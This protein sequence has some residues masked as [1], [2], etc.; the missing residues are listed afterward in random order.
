MTDDLTLT[1]HVTKLAML[2]EELKQRQDAL[3][4]KTDAFNESVKAERQTIEGLKR[5]L[6]ACDSGVR[7]LAVLE[8]ERTS[9]K[10][11]AP[12]IEIVESKEFD[13]DETAGLEWARASKMCL[14]PESLDRSAAI[15]IASVQPLPFVT[16][17]TVP[18]VRIAS[19]LTAALSAAT[20][21]AHH[22]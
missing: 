3:L 11:P 9:T 7:A 14:I 15:K 5:S 22:E 10:K 2:R 20:T 6:E 1:A 12:G 19:N 13:V 21:G 17:R 16:V 4:V 8:F 18:A